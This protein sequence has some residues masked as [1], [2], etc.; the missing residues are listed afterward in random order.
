MGARRADLSARPR[1]GWPPHHSKQASRLGPTASLLSLP[2]GPTRGDRVAS[3]DVIAHPPGHHQRKFR[4]WG[5]YFQEG[6]RSQ[7]KRGTRTRR[8]CQGEVSLTPLA[9]RAKPSPRRRG[10]RGRSAAGSSGVRGPSGERNVFSRELVVFFHFFSKKK[11]SKGKWKQTGWLEGWVERNGK[12]EAPVSSTNSPCLTKRRTGGGW[13]PPISR[14][15]SAGPIARRR[16]WHFRNMT[17]ERE[18]PKQRQL[19]LKYIRR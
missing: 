6:G 16:R 17:L 5:R 15:F 18:G 11:E 3:N 13:R 12:R 14:P 1:R 10:G 9:R 4:E 2:A 19:I 8:S 7:K